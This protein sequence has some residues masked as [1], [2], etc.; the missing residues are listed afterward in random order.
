[1][2]NRKLPPQLEH[3][4]DAMHLDWLRLFDAGVSSYTIGRSYGVRP[5]NVRT[6]LNRIK[7][8]YAESE[9]VTPDQCRRAGAVI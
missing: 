4:R 5:E 1:M 7:A 9:A 6:V 2:T 3:A 8:D